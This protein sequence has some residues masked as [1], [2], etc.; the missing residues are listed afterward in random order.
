MCE[1]KLEAIKKAWAG[2]YNPQVKENGWMDIN[3][4]TYSNDKFFDRLQFN[5]KRHSIRPKSLKGLDCNNG[6]TR[7][8]NENDLPTESGWY[9]FQIFPQENYTP[10]HSYWNIGNV[11]VGW[12][13]ET[14]THY[15]RIHKPNIPIY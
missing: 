4:K 10:N 11:K 6:W 13:I 9:E 8:D 5:D 15:R 12:F 2:F 7:I 1:L 3:A 14:Y